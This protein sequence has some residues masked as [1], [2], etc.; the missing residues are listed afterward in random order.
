MPHYATDKSLFT[1]FDLLNVCIL[2]AIAKPGLFLIAHLAFFGPAVVLNSVLWKKNTEKISTR[3]F[4]FDNI[5]NYYCRLVTQLT[6][7]PN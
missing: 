7:T 5:S 6:I 3:K 2:G 4:W 1:I